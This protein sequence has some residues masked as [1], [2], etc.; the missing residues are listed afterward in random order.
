MNTNEKNNTPST[1]SALPVAPI[2]VSVEVEVR[3][4][5]EFRPDNSREIYY[6]ADAELSSPGAR[7]STLRVKVVSKTGPVPTGLHKLVIDGFD[8]KKGEA[9]G[10]V[11]D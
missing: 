4:S 5:R 7:W 11:V 6:S 10:H 1:G 8:L 3:N 9:V 2:S